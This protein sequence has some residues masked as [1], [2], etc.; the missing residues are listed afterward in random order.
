[1]Y[2]GPS[3]WRV[4][5]VIPTPAPICIARKTLACGGT[6]RPGFSESPHNAAILADGRNGR[7]KIPYAFKHTS[8]RPAMTLLCARLYATTRSRPFESILSTSLAGNAG[9]TR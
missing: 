5:A 2:D 9:L 6:H 3:L 1:M 7:C 8:D 4:S